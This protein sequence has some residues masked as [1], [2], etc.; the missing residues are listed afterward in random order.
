MLK[1]ENISVYGADNYFLSYVKRMNKEELRFIKE[2]RLENFAQLEKMILEK[3]EV[4]FYF[5]NLY[6]LIKKYIIKE[7]MIDK[8]ATCIYESSNLKN[9]NERDL[10]VTEEKNFVKDLILNSVIDDSWRV[11][12]LDIENLNIRTLR[13]FLEHIT[14]KGENSLVLFP[15]IGNKTINNVIKALEFYEKQIVRQSKESHLIGT[16]L[17]TLNKEAKQ[18]IVEKEIFD[19]V[20]YFLSLD[21]DF[22]WG[23]RSANANNLLEE[24]LRS[25]KRWS[26]INRNRL[27]ETL[28]NYMTLKELESGA[29]ENH[30]LDRF[31]LEKSP[32]N[33][34]K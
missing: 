34:V 27:I 18:K 29:I 12:Y 21:N 11:T 1:L 8:E 23:R 20:E 16:N 2:K 17:F 24:C 10:E 7:H 25:E 5:I 26:I 28:S 9:I 22:I 3:E 19:Y 15:R 4:P 13:F 14:P 30:I 32:S 31:I 6:N 33:N